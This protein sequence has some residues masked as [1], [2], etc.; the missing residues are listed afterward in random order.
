M[1]EGAKD[2][3]RWMTLIAATIAA[4][5]SG[6]TFVLVASMD[7]GIK[8]VFEAQIEFDKS[9]SAVLKQLTENQLN[10]TNGI[11]RD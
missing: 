2:T 10:S 6:A 5:L 9:T 8:S 4:V 1:T 3:V 7:D 11:Y